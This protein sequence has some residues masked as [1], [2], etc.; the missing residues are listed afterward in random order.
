M[1][2]NFRGYLNL[3]DHKYKIGDEN[4]LWAATNYKKF[5]RMLREFGGY[6]VHAIGADLLRPWKKKGNLYKYMVN[7]LD[8][9]LVMMYING[10]LMYPHK[11]TPFT[12]PSPTHF[13]VLY[14]LKEINKMI[15]IKYWDYGLKTEQLITWKRF[16][17]TIYG[18][19]SITGR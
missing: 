12:L 16:K 10:K 3:F 6:K 5:N 14:E 13:V 11:F 19:S 17:K 8:T 18:V 7:Q 4:T 2:D 1:A 9:G 15:K